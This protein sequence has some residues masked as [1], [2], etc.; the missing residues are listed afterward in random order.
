MNYTPHIV[1]SLVGACAAVLLSSCASRNTF[2]NRVQTN[3]AGF[4]A[5]PDKEKSLATQGKIAEGMSRDG[6]Y[7]SWGPPA[8][9]AEGS[10]GG[11]T[12]E[13]WVYAGRQAVVQNSF[14]LGYGGYGGYRGYGGRRGYDCYY[15]GSYFY[16]G[17][18]VTYI[19]YTA[20]K[21]N[22]NNARVSSWETTSR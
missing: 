22:F 12:K 17:P 3:P 9:R 7:Y 6:V 11:V 18:T 8:R 2:E 16:G 15:P 21:V 20:A 1:R 13:T 4:E 19:P 5:L 14:G 10:S